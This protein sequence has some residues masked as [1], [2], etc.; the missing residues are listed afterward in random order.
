MWLIGILPGLTFTGADGC[1]LSSEPLT[2]PQSYEQLDDVS[3]FRFPQA[4]YEEA[5]ISATSSA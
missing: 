1:L 4:E 2:I 5:K 3:K